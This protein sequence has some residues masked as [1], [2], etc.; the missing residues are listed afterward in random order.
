MRNTPLSGKTAFVTGG[1]QG[2][3]RAIVETLASAGANVA[4]ADVNP[5]I[6]DVAAKI[7]QDTSACEVIGVRADVTSSQDIAA[8]VAEANRR[9]GRIDVLVNNAGIVG[10]RRAWSWEG[11]EDVWRETIE[12][13]LVGTYRVTKAVVPQMVQARAGRVINIASISGKQGSPGN[14][15]YS[16]SKHGVIGLTR[17]LAWEFAMLGLGEL[18][19]NA[20]CPGVVDT[21]LVHGEGGV[22]DGLAALTGESRE[23]VMDKYV[24]PMSW[25]HRLLDPQEIAD[26]VLYLASDR[27]RGITGQ[28]I[29]V[30]A[31]SVFY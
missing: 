21:P 23:V 20:V 25:Q 7:D 1:H 31:G 8:A 29:N 15:A 13:N 17:T 18:T 24:L 28:A 11:D 3:G 12:I 30:D 16:A 6:A 19:A 9:L 26:M 27:A 2:I 14:S 10:K 4:A 5:A 22:L